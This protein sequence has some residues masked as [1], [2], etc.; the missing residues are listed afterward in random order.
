MSTNIK[1]AKSSTT[2]T[3]M[4]AGTYPAVCCGVIDLGVQRTLFENKE[5]EVNQILLIWE[6]P[7][8][9]IEIDGEQKPRWLSRI[10]TFSVSEKSRLRQDLKSWRGR[11]FTEAELKDFDIKNVLNAP[12]VVG[13][14]KT[15]KNGNTYTNVSTVSKAMKGMD[16]PKPSKSHHFDIDKPETWEVFKELPE[17]IQKKIN[18]SITFEL[19]EIQLDENG[20][21]VSTKVELLDTEIE[22]DIALPF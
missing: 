1:N 14:A 8:E 3:P 10:Y 11:D 7:D 13:V 22:D 9:T 19:E 5:R 12:C 2:I 18:S 4:E 20:S 21:P 6:F 16:I 17:W 15:E